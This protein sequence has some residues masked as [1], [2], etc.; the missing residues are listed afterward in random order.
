MLTSKDHDEFLKN[1]EKALKLK[2]DKKYL[3]LETKEAKENEWRE[4]ALAIINL[5]KKDEPSEKNSK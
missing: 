5:I 3:D 4:K 2:N 1:I